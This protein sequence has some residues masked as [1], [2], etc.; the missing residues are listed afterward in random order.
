MKWKG[1]VSM[2]LQFQLM[3]YEMRMWT[4][5]YH[6]SNCHENCMKQKREKVAIVYMEN[7]QL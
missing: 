3:R 1:A 4:A 2:Q 5:H 6:L 7:I